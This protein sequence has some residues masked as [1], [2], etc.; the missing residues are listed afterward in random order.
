MST[1]PGFFKSP[2]MAKKFPL[3]PKHPERTC[4]G[5]D[6]YCSV[7]SLQCGNGSG[8][9]QHPAEMLGDDWYKWG[10]WGI[11]TTD[12]TDAPA[13]P[14]DATARPHSEGK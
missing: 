11:D 5:C 13:T 14:A 4:W 9:T 6:K 12:T 8:R 10:D 7:N 1:K 2:E 3:H